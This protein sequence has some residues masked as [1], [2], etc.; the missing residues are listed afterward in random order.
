MSLFR[1]RE[2]WRL[3]AE[4]LP[5]KTAKPADKK[6]T[7]TARSDV[8]IEQGLPMPDIPTTDIGGYVVTPEF[9]HLLE[10]VQTSLA[11]DSLTSIDVSNLDDLRMHIA[12]ILDEAVSSMDLIV[13][14]SEREH[15]LDQVIADTVGY[16]PI[17]PLLDRDDISEIMVNGPHKVYIEKDGRLY[18]TG[19]K[20]KDDDHVLRII[21]RIVTPLGRR[22]DQASPMVDARLPDGSRVNAI[23]PPLSLVGPTLTI[24]KFKKD[25][26]S[27]ADLIRFGTLTSEAAQFLEAAVRARLN[28]IVSGGTG[29]G[30]T[31]TLGV[32]S[33]YIPENERIITIEDAAEL[34]LRQPHVVRLESRPPNVEGKGAIGIRE[35]FVN[36]L[37]MRPDRIVVGEC[38]GPEALY[39]LQAMNTGHDGS[40]TTIHSNSPRDTLARIETMV[41]MAGMPLTMRAIR[42]QIASAVDMIIHISRMRDGTRKIVAISEI[43]GMEGET[44][45]MQ[46]IFVFKQEGFAEDGKVLGRLEPTGIRPNLIT[47]IETAGMSLPPEVFGLRLN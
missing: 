33:S 43:L 25:P 31:T 30:K 42:Q 19:V 22:I 15:M 20:F 32:I 7:P 47:K 35:L 39:M 10:T 26:L 4:K 1:K 44:I 12:P 3:G 16:G 14:R 2:T 5:E 6:T 13:G 37:R 28:I 38:R 46:D 34:R 17:Q 27:I 45:V 8:S 29:S 18:L 21:E 11:N 36:S 9:D 40:I 24:R 41:M 23:I